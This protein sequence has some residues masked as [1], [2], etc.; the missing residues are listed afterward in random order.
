MAGKQKRL[1]ICALNIF[2]KLQLENWIYWILRKYWVIFVS[3]RVIG[4]NGY[5]ATVMVSTASA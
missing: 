5:P 1:A 2:G 3:L 4:L